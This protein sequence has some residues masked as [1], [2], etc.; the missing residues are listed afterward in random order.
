MTVRRVQKGQG[1]G[2]LHPAHGGG[3]RRHPA[4]CWQ[5]VTTQRLSVSAAS[6]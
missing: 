5:A 4:A 6:V 3:P 1:H 2:L